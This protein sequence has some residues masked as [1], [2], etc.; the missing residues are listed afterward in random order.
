MK[1]QRTLRTVMMAFA[2]VASGYATPETAQAECR[3]CFLNICPER[4]WGGS[5]CKFTCSPWT[6]KCICET[7]LGPCTIRPQ[8]GL[9]PF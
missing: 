9:Q 8:L 3:S 1:A 4:N 2:L 7:L 6:M 5:G